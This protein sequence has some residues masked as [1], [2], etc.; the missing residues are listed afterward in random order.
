MLDD[1]PSEFPRVNE[2]FLGRKTQYGYTSRIK[3]D[4]V[5]LFNGLTKYH[6]NGGKS[7]T[8][9]FGEGRYGGEAVFVPR[10]SVN[11][12]EDEGWLIT[13]VY[14]TNNDTS[15]LVV[16]NARDI[17]G[18]PVARVLIPQRVPYGFHGAWVSQE[19]LN[20]SSK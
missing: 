12:D 18:K 3:N 19:Q 16:V 14:D 20:A 4:S 10:T 7:E 17:T 9:E 2:N 5:P 8:H 6:L 1:V 11:G 15:E 13:F